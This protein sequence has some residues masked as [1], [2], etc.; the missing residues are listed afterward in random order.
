M[1]YFKL[2]KNGIVNQNPVFVQVMS[3]CPLL[4]VTTSAVNAITMGL[5]TT[6]VLIC[7]CFAISA[8]RKVIPSEIR[9]VV[10]VIIVAGFVTILQL[11]ME[12]YLPPAI[13]E[14]LGIFIP[15]IVVNCILFARIESFASKNKPFASAVDALG[16][17][18]GFTLGLFVIGVIREFFGS[19]A[20]FGIELISDTNSHMVIMV[21]APG[22]FFTLGALIMIIHSIR[23][24]RGGVGV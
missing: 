5:A 20:V 13:N 4:A 1:N 9:I 21:L 15:L 23:R 3:L 19:G 18:L 11:V 14:S 6:A 7:A 24:R 2:I 8:V 12:A 10:S 22:A 17:G 16:M